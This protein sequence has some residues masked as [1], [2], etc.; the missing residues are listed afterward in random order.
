MTATP[1]TST[2]IQVYGTDS[3]KDTSSV[4]R[5]LEKYNAPYEYIDIENNKDAGAW[6]ESVAGDAPITPVID[7]YGQTLFNPDD[8]KIFSML[9][10][11]GV[12]KAL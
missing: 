6:V 9:K 11:S 8:E 7:F 12:R 10:N 5:T 2:L 4:R 3:C 1:K